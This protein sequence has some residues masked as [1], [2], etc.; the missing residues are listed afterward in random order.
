LQA[1][2]A[3]FGILDQK[4]GYVALGG[5]GTWGAKEE[6]VVAHLMFRI[7]DHSDTTP[8]MEITEGIAAFAD[9]SLRAI[10]VHPLELLPDGPVLFQSYPNPFNTQTVIEYALDQPALVRLDIY[11]VLGQRIIRLV[12]RDQEGGMYTTHW[13]GKDRHDRI[14]ATGIYFIR[15]QVKNRVLVGKMLLLK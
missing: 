7:I 6:G 1:E 12:N 14:V 4:P 13:D 10:R 8:Q 15:L 3:L 9:G 2:N 11:N 5:H